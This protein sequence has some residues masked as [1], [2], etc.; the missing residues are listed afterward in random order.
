MQCF[1]PVPVNQIIV[2]QTQLPKTNNSY[3]N[4]S[5][6]TLNGCKLQISQYSFLYNA[7][8]GRGT[9]S[10]INTNEDEFTGQAPLRYDFNLETFHVPPLTST[11]AQSDGWIPFPPFLKVDVVPDIIQGNIYEESG[12]VNHILTPQLYLPLRTSLIVEGVVLF[13]IKIS[14][15]K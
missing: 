7:E 3:N 10:H 5:I 11:T 9:G 12:K 8:G 4:I 15:N 14:F 13:T 2:S 6:K 1:I